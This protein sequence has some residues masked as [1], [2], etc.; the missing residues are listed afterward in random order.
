MTLKLATDAA[1]PHVHVTLHMRVLSQPTFKEQ[2][3]GYADQK[4]QHNYI[5]YIWIFL[6]P[7]QF[8]L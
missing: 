4:Q 2:T 8:E 7:T 3:E 5:I 6:N 1:L